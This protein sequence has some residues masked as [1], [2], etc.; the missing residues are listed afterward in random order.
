MRYDLDTD[1]GKTEC[2]ASAGYVFKDVLTLFENSLS[3]KAQ[4]RLPRCC[5]NVHNLHSCSRQIFIV[6]CVM[7]FSA[8]CFQWW[9]WS[10]LKHTQN[11]V[12]TSDRV[13][14]WQDGLMK[15]CNSLGGTIKLSNHFYT[16]AWFS[17]VVKRRRH[18]SD[19]CVGQSFSNT[20]A[21]KLSSVYVVSEKHVI[22]QI[23]VRVCAKIALW[24]H[25]LDEC[26]DHWLFHLPAVL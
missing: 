4:N 12:K 18:F 19:W 1:V 25:T 7:F 15:N 3:G 13:R 23:I 9:V 17:D 26:S 10:K 8:V 16:K 11:R 6:V 21:V 24:H 2:F 5:H 20:P 14:F 22:F